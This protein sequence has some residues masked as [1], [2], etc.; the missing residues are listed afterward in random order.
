[1]KTAKQLFICIFLISLATLVACEN[2][3]STECVCTDGVCAC[4]D[5]YGLEKVEVFITYALKDG[6]KAEKASMVVEGNY[7]LQYE[8]S[9]PQDIA[10]KTMFQ[11]T[12]VKLQC[13]IG[14]VPV[15]SEVHFMILVPQGDE[16]VAACSSK[17]RA[18]CLGELRVE[19]LREDGTKEFPEDILVTNK[20]FEKYYAYRVRLN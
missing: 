9:E 15:E 7:Q 8:D 5:D 11:D 14:M 16:M 18:E 2:D 1:M 20:S 13:S 3:E 4:P 10:C 17:Y 12:D 6:N 19:I